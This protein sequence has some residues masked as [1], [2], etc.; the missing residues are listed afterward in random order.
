MAATSS[1][2]HAITSTADRYRR[3]SR[4]P[5][6]SRQRRKVATDPRRRGRLPPTPRRNSPLPF[7]QTAAVL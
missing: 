7:R 5:P 3:P 4:R 6:S 1:D 2:R